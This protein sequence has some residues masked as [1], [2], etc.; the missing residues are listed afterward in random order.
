MIRIGIL[1]FHHSENYGAFLQAYALCNRLNEERDIQAEIINFRMKK[2]YLHYTHRK[3]RKFPNLR[4][5]LWCIRHYRTYRF[6]K[7]LNSSLERG[8]LKMPLSESALMSDSIEDFQNFVRGKYDLI[9]AGSDEIWKIDS[10]RG[11]PTPYWLPGDLK[12]RKI[13]YA[14]SS[15]ADFSKLDA[16][17]R[18]Q[19]KIYLS[20]FSFISV[21]DEVTKYNIQKY[22]LPEREIYIFPDPSFIYEFHP[23]AGRGRKILKE[24]AGLDPLKKTAVVMMEDSEIA[25][26]IRSEIADEYQL[27]AVF[28]RKKGYRNLGKL[29]PFE[30]LDVIA[31][32]DMIC[33]SYFHAV[34][35]SIIF[36][37]PFVAFAAD[38]KE[39]KLSAVLDASGNSERLYKK[40]KKL[41]QKGYIRDIVSR[42]AVPGKGQDYVAGSR[43]NFKEFLSIIRTPDQNGA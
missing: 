20:D 18:E 37:T 38:G 5:L 21:R 2:E 41:F 28:S 15:R 34:C 42:N 24:R 30:W 43:E 16:G 31:G 22:I 19:I 9:I 11:F 25:E 17:T 3:Y 1:T 7:E 33:A 8:Y 14:A 27:I 26:Q 6:K 13:S 23:D 10:V 32:A 12:C 4:H 36:G 35:F 40:T 29:D 39:S